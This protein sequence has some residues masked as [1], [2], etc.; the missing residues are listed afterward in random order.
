MAPPFIAYA[1]VAGPTK[2]KSLLANA[3]EQCKGYRSIL[4][5][6]SGTKLWRHIMGGSWNDKGLWLTGNAWAAY[7]MLRVQQ[8]I[9]KSVYAADLKSES[10]DLLDWTNE[11]LN[12]TWARQVRSCRSFAPSTP[13]SRALFAC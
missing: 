11:I 4:Q 5:D 10:A 8:T 7:G 2:S 6:P 13:S 1:G 12:A 3:H 9:A